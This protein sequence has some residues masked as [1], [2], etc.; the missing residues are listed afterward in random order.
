MPEVGRTRRVP[1]TRATS[2][3]AK[4]VEFLD[5][6]ERSLASGQYVVATS[7]SVHAAINAA[8]AI[9]IGRLGVRAASQDHGQARQ[10][11]AS[12]GREGTIAARALAR[13]LPLKSKAEYE[14]D[15]IPKGTAARAVT[16]ATQIVEVA[17]LV[18]R[19]PEGT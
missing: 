12:A 6:A 14:P 11:V 15:E 9:C 10:L 8:D 18:T 17:G 5:A 1:A 7:L 2:Y 4:A 16:W 3:L 19:P 13:L